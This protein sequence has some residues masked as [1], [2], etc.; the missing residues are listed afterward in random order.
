MMIIQSEDRFKFKKYLIMNK[1]IP[2]EK[3]ER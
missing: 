3:E 2:I 1:L